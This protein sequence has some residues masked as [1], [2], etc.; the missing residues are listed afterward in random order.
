MPSSRRRPAAPLTYGHRPAPPVSQRREAR[1]QQREPLLEVRDLKTYFFTREGIVR[2]VDGVSFDIY[3][4]EILGV[5]G[6]SGCGKSVTASSLMRLIPQPPGKITEGSIT[7]IEDG[8]RTDI[9]KA[10]DEMRR[11]RGRS[12]SMI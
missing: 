7:L 1:M 2:A 3:K 10:D 6:E 8:A 9:V 12:I 5:V 11:I 4:G